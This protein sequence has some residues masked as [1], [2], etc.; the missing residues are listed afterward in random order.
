MAHVGGLK[1]AA[2]RTAFGDVSNISNFVRPSKD[3]SALGAKGEL[4]IMEKPGLLQ[5]E[6]KATALL[7]PAQRPLS[8]S[9]LKSL[10]SN[11]T[12]SSH[13]V[14]T[15]QPL[16]EIHQSV[17]PSVQAANT[18][19]VLTKR[20]MGVFKD[21]LPTQP[22]HASDLHRPISSTTAI[23]RVQ[24]EIA[25]RLEVKTRDEVNEPQAKVRRTKSQH[26]AASEPREDEISTLSISDAT[27]AP[28]IRSDGVYIDDRG[29]VQFYQY[30]DDT[31]AVK[32]PALMR[33]NRVILPAE[34][35]VADGSSLK[36]L[37]DAE[38]EITQPEP[39]RKHRL[40][41]VSEPEECWDEEEEEE[42]YDEDGYVT[43]R[44]YKS[45]GENTTSGA[46]TVF[47]PK[48]NQKVKREL[49]AAKELIESTRTTEDIDDESW[50]TTMVA[51]Y[52]DEIFQYMKDLEASIALDSR[53]LG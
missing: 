4:S 28:A 11:V 19:K 6:K 18:R 14:P 46:T 41:S 9:G 16:L 8:V 30:S 48:V 52:G 5:P 49:A 36:L 1:A 33:D 40:T 31:D 47:F 35:K 24:Q 25:S 2:K 34:T 43:A 26:I 22:D 7:R 3:D 39:A 13:V 37:R 51:E 53:G 12:N 21:H 17:Q 20:N 38:L 29:D 42:N 10:L 50:D 32:G 45:R 15:K 44:S 23:A 27:E